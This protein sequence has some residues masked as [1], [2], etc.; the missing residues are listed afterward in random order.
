M[1]VATTISRGDT[2]VLMIHRFDPAQG[3][4]MQV[5]YFRSRIIVTSRGR[6]SYNPTF[7]RTKILPLDKL[8]EFSLIKLMHNFH[9]KQLPISFAETWKTNAERNPDRML[10]NADDLYIPAHRVGIRLPLFSFPLA[11]NSA[12][13]EK[14]NPRQ[15][16]YLKYL[17]NYMLISL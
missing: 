12:P 1:Q 10:R 7:Q 9:F 5:I 17:K 15:H 13:G 8:I 2:L 3:Q 4:S 6:S 16:L 11:R 14:L